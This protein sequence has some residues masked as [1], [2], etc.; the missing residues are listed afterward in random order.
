MSEEHLNLLSFSTR[1]GVG[2]GLGDCPRLVASAFMNGS[3]DLACRRV[4]AALGLK[5]AGLAVVLARIY[6]Q[7]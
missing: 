4:R 3:R 1:D 2:L 6:V 7:T 5:R